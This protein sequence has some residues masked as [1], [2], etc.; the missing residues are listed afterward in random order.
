[1][2]QRRGPMARRRRTAGVLLVAALVGSVPVLGLAAPPSSEHQT[3][4]ANLLYNPGF[5]GAYVVGLVHVNDWIFRDNIFTPEGWVTWWR[6][7]IG[8]GG[9]FGQPEVQVISADHPNYGYDADLPRI[10]SGWQSLKV[11]NMWRPQDAGIYQC[12]DGLQPGATVQLT[13]YAHAWTCDSDENL[14]YTCVHPWNQIAFQVG[15]ESNGVADPFSP[16]IIW[17]PP[18][19]GMIAPDHFQMIGPATAR[20]GDSGSVCVYL[21]SQAKWAFQHLDAYWDETS[22][23]Y[24]SGVEVPTNTPV[25]PQPTATPA[26]ELP[27]STPVPPATPTP[28]ETVPTESP[29]PTMVPDTATPRPTATPWH[30]P[31]PRPDGSVAHTVRAG[32]TLSSIGRA[33][34]VSVEQLRELNQGSIGP[35]DLILVGQELVVALVGSAY[36]PTATPAPTPTEA[37]E[38]TLEEEASAGGDGTAE[39]EGVR[40]GAQASAPGEG[41]P[42]GFGTVCVLCFLD[43]NL[44]TY[45]DQG[46]EEA[47]ADA[48]FLV[49]GPAGV[50]AEY[51]SDGANEPHCVS[52]LPAGQYRVEYEPPGG[53]VASGPIEWAVPLGGDAVFSHHFGCVLPETSEASVGADQANSAASPPL[54]QGLA[55]GEMLQGLVSVSGVLV[56]GLSGM[57]AALF[58]VSRRMAGDEG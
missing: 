40:A 5:E 34:G 32:D 30:T 47:M 38:P 48:R 46:A 26:P 13:A 44:D 19:P 43:R 8:D 49:V 27:T 52:G 4:T 2:A 56:L 6:Q 21:R 50:V 9:E 3:E 55:L 51:T 16:M 14:G 57:A 31:T 10:Y 12:V 25:P 23:V 11:F 29:T 45:W 58:Y 7:G 18:D 28:A 54:R 1:M 24:V 42:D 41:Y 15:I 53:L 37:P 39:E 33:Y 36:T 20:V 17:A 22:L 35:G